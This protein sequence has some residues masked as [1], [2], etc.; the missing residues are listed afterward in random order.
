MFGKPSVTV[1]LVKD[2]RSKHISVNAG[3]YCPGMLVDGWKVV[4][5]Y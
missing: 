3:D 5:I 4:A 1:K 2:G